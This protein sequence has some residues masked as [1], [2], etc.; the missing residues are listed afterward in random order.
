MNNFFTII[1]IIIIALILILINIDT[2]KFYYEDIK[3][4]LRSQWY[5]IF[6]HSI[7]NN[8]LD[9]PTN[10]IYKFAIIT[11]EN[12]IEP[13][14]KLHNQILQDYCKKWNYEYLFYNSCVHN[15]YWCKMYYVLSALLTNKYDYVLWMDS[16]S[17]IKNKNY[18]LDLIAN[19][20]S[21]DI[22]IGSDNKLTTNFCAG[23]FMI[24]N[25]SIG[26]SYIKNCINLHTDKCKIKSN[27][28]LKGIWAGLCYE[29]GIMNL[30][31]FNKYHK[32]TTCLPTNI[33]Y[34]YNITETND[35]CDVD[36]FILHLYNSKNFLR[37]KCF[38]RFL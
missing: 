34:N 19:K 17:I 1:I 28:M 8:M 2:T 35:L 37:E 31:I 30:L 9:N 15:V 16:D 33:I 24:K 27:N 12:R 18:S 32:Y 10:N 22:F 6:Y 26:I 5:K 4:T 14:V 3:Y 29:Q 21:S 23:V 25:S 36:T 38:K 7:N 20:Y 11:F 13:Y